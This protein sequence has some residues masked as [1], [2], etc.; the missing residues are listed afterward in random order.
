MDT[1]AAVELEPLDESGLRVDVAVVGGG[2]TGLSVA[3][4]LARSGAS[5]AVVEARQLASGVTAGTTGK[6]TSQH[7]LIYHK[8]RSRLGE[9]SARLYG[10]A[11]QTAVE[12]VVRLVE[13]EEIDCDLDRLPA[14]VYAEDDKDLRQVSDEVEAACQA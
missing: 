5:V 4:E 3:F 13:E 9:E 1:S 12:D 14:Y 7:G 8:L 2:I 10:E 6:L 11:N